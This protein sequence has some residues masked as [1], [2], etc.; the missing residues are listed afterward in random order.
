[1]GSAR[2]P[3]RAP[4]LKM[5]LTKSF[6][7]ATTPVTQRQWFDLMATKPWKASPEYMEGQESPDFPALAVV[8]REAK[9]FADKFAAKYSVKADLPTD[10]QWE[11]AAR[12]G[13]DI[14]YPW[15]NDLAEAKS[16]AHVDFAGDYDLAVPRSVGTLL[17][18]AWGLYDMAGNVREI[19]RDLCVPDEESPYLKP[20]HFT[21]SV[22]F[23]M[24]KGTHYITRNSGFDEGEVNVYCGRRKLLSLEER[25]ISVGVR[26]VVNA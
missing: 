18:N 24:T 1:M 22:D 2:Y 21:G 14:E 26:L 19:V 12:A 4:R 25:D 7:V 16:Y 17:P 11:Y 23:E 13:K 9:E 20:R 3:E 8:Y 15:G 10:C 6:L 5:T